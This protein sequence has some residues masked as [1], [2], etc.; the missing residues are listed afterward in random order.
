MHTTHFAAVEEL[1]SMVAVTL[2]RRRRVRAVV[3]RGVPCLVAFEL[4][5]VGL[6]FADYAGLL[7]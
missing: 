3:W 1:K 2:R 6:V 5:L 7:P 4:A